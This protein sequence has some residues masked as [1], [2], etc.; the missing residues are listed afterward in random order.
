MRW[1]ILVIVGVVILST[2]NHFWPHFPYIGTAAALGYMC[3]AERWRR[4]SG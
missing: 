4:K 2:L 3:G 1:F